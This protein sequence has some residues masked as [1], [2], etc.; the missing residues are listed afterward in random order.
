MRKISSCFAALVFVGTS[1]AFA[2]DLN[3]QQVQ[4]TP[5]SEAQLD[6]VAAGAVQVGNLVAVDV[7]NVANNLD[8]A[9]NNRVIVA[10]PVNAA[11]AAGVGVLGAGAAAAQGTQF[12]RVGIVR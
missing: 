4:L 11:V 6:T 2:Q 12:N 7:T 8:V 3:R 1:S 5:M 9:N 10:I